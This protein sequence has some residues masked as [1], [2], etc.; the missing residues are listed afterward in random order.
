MLNHRVI[1]RHLIHQAVWPEKPPGRA[2]ELSVE[3]W[4]SIGDP[5]NPFDLSKV[6]TD[7]ASG[8]GGFFRTFLHGT[9]FAVPN[10]GHP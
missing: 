5:S 3:T 2:V 7:L 8:S 10:F 1:R 4:E 6:L 9:S